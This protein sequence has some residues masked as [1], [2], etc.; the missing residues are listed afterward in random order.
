MF[1]LLSLI[2]LYERTISLFF[3]TYS[4]FL[5]FILFLLFTFLFSFWYFTFFY[6][7]YSLF[8]YFLPALLF[9]SC[10]HFCLPVL[11]CSLLLIFHSVF[12]FRFYFFSIFSLALSSSLLMTLS[13]PKKISKKFTPNGSSFPEDPYLYSSSCLDQILCIQ[14]ITNTH[15]CP[16]IS[17]QHI[18]T[19]Q[20]SVYMHMC[21]FLHIF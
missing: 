15:V 19:V 14:Q 6:L 18:D 21:N 1:Y 10:S 4:L 12:S 17:H 9:S 16:I 5:L 8:S 7:I 13:L 11:F 20:N 3:F 2:L